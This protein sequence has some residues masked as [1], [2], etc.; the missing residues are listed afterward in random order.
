MIQYFTNEHNHKVLNNKLWVEDLKWIEQAWQSSVEVR[1]WCRVTNFII[2]FDFFSLREFGTEEIL[3]AI[4][5][6]KEEKKRK[7]VVNSCKI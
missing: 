2:F 3:D 7:L 5:E 1:L 6:E 4:K